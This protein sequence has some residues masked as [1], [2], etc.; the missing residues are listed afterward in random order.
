MQCFTTPSIATNYV[1]GNELHCL[2]RRSR[3]YGGMGCWYTWCLLNTWWDRHN[4]LYHPETILQQIVA[5]SQPSSI[6]V[7]LE[8]GLLRSGQHDYCSSSATFVRSCPLFDVGYSSSSADCVGP[9]NYAPR[10]SIQ[11]SSVMPMQPH[12]ACHISIGQV[13]SRV[14]RWRHRSVLARSWR[15]EKWG[16]ETL[17]ANPVATEGGMVG[18]L[19][20]FVSS[21][22]IRQNLGE[23]CHILDQ[24]IRPIRCWYQNIEPTISVLGLCWGFWPLHWILKHFFLVLPEHHSSTMVVRPLTRQNVSLAADKSGKEYYDQ[25]YVLS[26]WTMNKSFADLWKQRD[27]MKTPLT[28]DCLNATTGVLQATFDAPDILVDPN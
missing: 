24:V 4:T 18:A 11:V 14:W 2:P 20:R 21:A 6:T 12:G 28:Y 7:H 16:M 3:I 17:P 15:S 19:R 5:L 13:S 9:S 25:F 27:G 8:R 1:A 23:L 22:L 10:P 26:I